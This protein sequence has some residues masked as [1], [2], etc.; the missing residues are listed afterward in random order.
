MNKSGIE[1]KIFIEEILQ[2]KD[3]IVKF[4]IGDRSV[5]LS[6]S[7]EIK[8]IDPVEEALT[9]IDESSKR[10][11]KRQILNQYSLHPEKPWGV[12]NKADIRRKVMRNPF[13]Q[14]NKVII[15]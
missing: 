12:L 2:K 11:Q 10:I 3:K 5:V 8:T 15:Y 13:E 7:K 1:F 14:T 4:N 6:E 9:R